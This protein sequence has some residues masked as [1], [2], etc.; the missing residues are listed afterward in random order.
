[1]T[2]FIELDGNIRELVGKSSSKKLLKQNRIAAVIYSEDGSKNLNIDLDMKKFETEYY[3]GNVQLKLFKL[4]INGKEYKVIPYQ[5]DIHPV[6]DR[7][8]HIS[9]IPVD[10]KKEIKVMIPL[11]CINSERA[12]G[13]K[14]GG[15]LN[16]IKRK[17][18]FYVDPLNIPE[19][20]VLDCGNLLL[21]QSKRI[22]DLKLPEGVRPTT[23]KDIII[24]SMVGRGKNTAEDLAAVAGTNTA[25]TTTQPTANKQNKK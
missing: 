13:A 20:V 23:K 14:R 17:L 10:G 22:S 2:N 21:K 25:T 11:C 16:I 6:T 9:F 8:R 18:Q 15:Y 24:V 1:M 5:I 12:P 4:N 3:K 19:K 7:P